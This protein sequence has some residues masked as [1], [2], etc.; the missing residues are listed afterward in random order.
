[1]LFHKTNSSNPKRCIKWIT[2]IITIFKI[3]S[4]GAKYYI[5]RIIITVILLLICIYS[6]LKYNDPDRIIKWHDDTVGWIVSQE[7]IKHT[8]EV[9]VSEIS[10]FV[11]LDLDAENIKNI[12]DLKYLDNLEELTL[13]VKNIRNQRA[14]KHLGRLDRL[15][16]TNGDMKTLKYIKELNISTLVLK[17]FRLSSIEPLSEIDTL[18]RLEITDTFIADISSLKDLSGLSYLSLTNVSSDSQISLC[19]N[20][21]YKEMYL[22]NVEI[23]LDSLSHCTDLISL[24]L[25]NIHPING[26][27]LELPDS[28]R[29]AAFKECGLTDLNLFL[30]LPGLT[31]L[32]VS[33]NTIQDINGLKALSNLEELSLAYNPVQ[34]LS[35]IQYLD[36]IAA[37]NLSG[38][39]LEKE[40][41]AMLSKMR[42]EELSVSN[43]NI[44]DLDF[45]KG[46]YEIKK[47]DLSNNSIDDIRMLGMYRQDL[48]YLN[49]S[50][51]PIEDLTPLKEWAPS[52]YLFVDYPLFEGV[53]LDVSGINLRKIEHEKGVGVIK[54]IALSKLSVRNCGLNNMDIVGTLSKLQFLDVSE[55]SIDEFI[56]LDGLPFL[57]DMIAIDSLTSKKNLPY[58]SIMLTPPGTYGVPSLGKTYGLSFFAHAK[59]SKKVWTRLVIE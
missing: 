13:N 19:E 40:E 9:K 51:N 42:L 58:R 38:I 50:E 27:D 15:V 5:K 52:I 57:K 33:C 36:G 45:L 46:Q 11:K 41:L 31:S 20:G 26:T 23:D 21:S 59:N 54:E 18:S 55:N 10:D 34:N 24:G 32:D 2:T 22:S 35:P 25:E 3:D 48:K 37:L 43:C 14:L 28:L 49:I 8:D 17:N 56:S 4:R 16:L 30:T 29:K 1:M 47:L 7:V 6:I 53:E 44:S 39:K 12:R